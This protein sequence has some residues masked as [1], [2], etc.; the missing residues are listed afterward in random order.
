MEDKEKP[1]LTPF[2]QAL[3]DSV[4]IEYENFIKE[5]NQTE[6]SELQPR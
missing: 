5:T 4:L 3:L 1:I 6:S 2:Q